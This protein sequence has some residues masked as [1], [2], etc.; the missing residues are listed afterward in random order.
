MR[1]YVLWLRT[2]VSGGVPA[3]WVPFTPAVRAVAGASEETLVLIGGPQRKPA[4]LYFRIRVFDKAKWEKNPGFAFWNFERIY[5][6]KVKTNW[7]TH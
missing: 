7:Q 6:S 4:Y 5:R 3:G 2:T 1:F